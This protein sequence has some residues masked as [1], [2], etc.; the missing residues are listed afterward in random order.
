[1]INRVSEMAARCAAAMTVDAAMAI[2][3]DRAA[4]SFVLT[5]PP[6]HHNGCN[7]HLEACVAKNE[8]RFVPETKEEETVDAELGFSFACHG[9]CILNSTAIAIKHIQAKAKAIPE[10]TSAHRID[11]KSLGLARKNLKWL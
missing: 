11:E 7:E 6:G 3:E 4:N 9:G 8:E 5:R 1:V 2:L 10:A